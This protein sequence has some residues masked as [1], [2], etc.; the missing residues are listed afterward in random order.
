MKI[1]KIRKN[2]ILNNSVLLIFPAV[3]TVVTLSEG[4]VASSEIFSLGMFWLLC[5]LI[6]FVPILFRIEVGSNDIKTFF[7]G[8]QTSHIQAEDVE[9]LEYGNLFRGGLGVGKGL[10]MWVK[11][12]KGRKAITIGEKAYGKEAVEHMKQVLESK[13]LN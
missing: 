9:V 6:T 2:Y 3:L 4:S 11:T 1:Y 10:K 12:S 8:F 13:L 7:F 5:L